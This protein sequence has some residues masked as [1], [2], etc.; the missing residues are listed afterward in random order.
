MDAA[1]Q[2]EAARSPDEGQRMTADEDE[3]NQDAK[4]PERR[5]SSRV[6]GRI[7]VSVSSAS[8]SKNKGLSA[9]LRPP[10]TFMKVVE[11]EVEAGKPLDLVLSTNLVIRTVS[12]Y[13]IVFYNVIVGDQIIEINDI[14]PM[15]IS[16]FLSI[17]QSEQEKL[18]L[19][20]LR[21]WNLQPATESRMAWVKKQDNYSY[22]IVDVYRFENFRNG[23]D[24]KFINKQCYV[25]KVEGNSRGAHAFLKGDRLLDVDSIPITATTDLKFVRRQFN[26]V[27]AKDRK[28]SFLVE[29]VNSLRSS[30]N[31]SCYALT[32]EPGEPEMG[33]DA[34]EIGVRESMRHALLHGK[35]FEEGG[36]PNDSITRR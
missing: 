25:T 14:A 10:S 23:F 8:R 18:K 13:S 27:M 2:Q 30:P 4:P 33:D 15:G 7:R 29:R 17:M 20:L 24:V 35:Y 3:V 34:T 28:C 26:K 5:R 22:F 31:P 19:S 32:R 9:E 12:K 1:Q 16:E 6:V 36:E 21:A 11:V